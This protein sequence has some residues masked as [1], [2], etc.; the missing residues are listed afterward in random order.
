MLNEGEVLIAES[1]Q[2]Q[3]IKDATG[4][5]IIKKERPAARKQALIL[6]RGDQLQHAVFGSAVVIDVIDA[7]A[8]VCQ[9]ETDEFNQPLGGHPA[10]GILTISTDY[11]HRIL[12]VIPVPAS[13]RTAA[14]IEAEAEEAAKKA[15][16][17]LTRKKK[18]DEEKAVIRRRRQINAAAAKVT[19]VR[20]DRKTNQELI[21]AAGIGE[22]I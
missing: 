14:E 4:V 6:H 21:N 17:K 2:R 13:V 5:H 11:N 12:S 15:A 19:A 10:N 18:T 8:C 9:F 1:T 3:V 16:A 20:F 22:T 7:S